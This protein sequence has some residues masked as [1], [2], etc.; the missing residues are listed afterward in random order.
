M[1]VKGLRRS[2]NIIHFFNNFIMLSV[3]ISEVLEDLARFN[4][5]TP[6]IFG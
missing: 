6:D 3:V 4:T 5:F 1:K 2:G